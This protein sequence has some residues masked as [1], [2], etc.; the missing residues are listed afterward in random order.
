MPLMAVVTA[1]LSR[2]SDR[3]GIRRGGS[4]SSS[5]NYRS[6]L[7]SSDLVMSATS[8]PKSSADSRC[9]ATNRLSAAAESTY[10]HSTVTD[11]DT[12]RGRGRQAKATGTCTGKDA[13]IGTSNGTGTGTGTGIAMKQGQ[14]L[15]MTQGQ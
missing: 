1:A 2:G 4:A 8:L 11:P 6:H 14:A 9:A 3:S 12:C 15:V 13:S 5:E 7:L 10:I